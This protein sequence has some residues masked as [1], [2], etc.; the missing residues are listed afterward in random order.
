MACLRYA[1]TL[2][3]PLITTLHRHQCATRTGFPNY[4]GLHLCACAFI[5]L[6]CFF[7]HF[8]PEYALCY[9]MQELYSTGFSGAYTVDVNIL[10]HEYRVV[11]VTV[12]VGGRTRG[13]EGNRRAS[14]ARGEMSADGGGHGPRRLRSYVRER[15]EREKGT[16]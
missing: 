15:K 4:P 16:E 13:P 1:L 8:G 5:S 3:L 10:E 11:N 2:A 9:R 6:V 12:Q 14:A 7:L